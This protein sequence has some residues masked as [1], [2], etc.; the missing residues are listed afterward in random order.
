MGLDKIKKEFTIKPFVKW[1]GGKTR[2]LP[3]INRLV[4]K[5]INVFYEP[6]VGGGSVFL[7]ML[8]RMENG[9]LHINAFRLSD[10][11]EILI[12]AY[13]CVKHDVSKVLQHLKRLKREYQSADMKS[14]EKNHSHNMKDEWTM[15]DVI[16]H[17]KSYVYY[18]YRAKYN[19][20]LKK[21]RK[22]KK[23]R[24]DPFLAALFIFLNKTCFRGLYTEN[25]LGQ[26]NVS[27][28]HYM[29]PSIYT[30]ENLKSVSGLLRKYKV[31]FQAKQ[32]LVRSYNSWTLPRTDFVFLDPPY[33][34]LQNTTILKY[35]KNTPK[36]QHEHVVQVCKILT[37]RKIPFICCNSLTPFTISNF[38]QNP[39]FSTTVHSISHLVD[40][41]SPSKK[42]F[43]IFVYLKV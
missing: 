28:G 5:Q 41:K 2:L 42:K 25:R 12:N 23:K 17:G 43:E 29:N 11:N 20:L 38:V 27:F 6:F 24:R 33:V 1:V 37:D 40:S 21:R 14:L 10:A 13:Q 4:P 7:H 39:M 30:V 3:K 19:V 8:Q 36:F 26:F 18:Y 34:P 22:G 16:N 31:R 35:T 32:F 9:S 15:K